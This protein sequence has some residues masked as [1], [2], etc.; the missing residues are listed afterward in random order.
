MSEIVFGRPVRGDINARLRQMHLAYGESVGHKCGDCVHL[1]RYAKG[2]T[3]HKCTLTRQ[4]GGR[5]TDW[6]STWP[7]CGMFQGWTP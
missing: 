1:K 3:W 2:S 4:S 6:G 5:G 7:A